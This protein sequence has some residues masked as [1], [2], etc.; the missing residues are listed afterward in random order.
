MA[1]ARAPRP[2]EVSLAA[3]PLPLGVLDS[4]AVALGRATL[5][6]VSAVQVVGYLATRLVEASVPEQ[7]DLAQAAEDLAQGVAPVLAVE[8]ELPSTNLPLR[9]TALAA[10]LSAPSQKRTTVPM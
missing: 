9:R 8:Q 1:L 4:V 10:L 5:V 2:A 7:V 3:V 6:V